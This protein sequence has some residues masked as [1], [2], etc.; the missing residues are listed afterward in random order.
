MRLSKPELTMLLHLSQ[1]NNR[2]RGIARAMNRSEKQVYHTL[3]HLNK[4]GIVKLYRGTLT[5]EPKLHISLLLQFLSNHPNITGLLSNSGI[6]ILTCLIDHDRTVEEIQTITGYK[7]STIFYKLSEARKRSIITANEKYALNNR[8]W[9]DIIVLLKSLQDYNSNIDDRVPIGSIIYHRT[10][11]DIVFSTKQELPAAK[12]AFSAYEHYGISIG[13]IKN[14]YYLPKKRLTKKEIMIHSLYV[15]EKEGGARNII[16]FA[17]FYIKV[18]KNF[19]ISHRVIM[20]IDI[21]LKGG[22][23]KGYPSL[24]EIKERAELYDIRV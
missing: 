16:F 2:I 8:L 7:R 23:V 3:S 19:G 4:K 21:I 9:P 17:L 24:S 14:Y 6:P 22:A 11:D 18:R 5:I 20:N 15:I 1:G 12:T 13:G 10:D